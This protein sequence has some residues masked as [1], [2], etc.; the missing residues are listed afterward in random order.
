MKFTRAVDYGLRA[1]VLMSRQ[2][3]GTRFFLQDLAEK[4]GLPRNYLVKILK[5]LAKHEIVRSH[6]GI[7]GGFS[8]AWEPARVSLREVV[9]AIDGPITVMH[10]MTDPESCSHAGNCAIDVTLGELRERIVD[11]LQ[12]KTLGDLLR[13]QEQIDAGNCPGVAGRCASTEAVKKD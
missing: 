13:L 2:P 5:S 9:E 12:G 8:L 6:R 10:C 1:L 4:A 11:E 3:P 7:K